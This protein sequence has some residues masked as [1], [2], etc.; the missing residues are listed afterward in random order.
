MRRLA[1]PIL[2]LLACTLVSL[3]DVQGAPSS[4]GVGFAAPPVQQVREASLSVPSPWANPPLPSALAEFG[5][6]LADNVCTGPSSTI[7]TIQATVWTTV[8]V[9]PGA[10]L[11]QPAVSVLPLYHLYCVLLI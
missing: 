10:V 9:A 1:L 11:K 2:T 3:A 5:E 8:A 7:A 6:G 4:C